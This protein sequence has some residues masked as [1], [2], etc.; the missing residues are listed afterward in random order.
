MALHKKDMIGFL[1]GQKFPNS[2]ETSSIPGKANQRTRYRAK[3]EALPGNSLLALCKKEFGKKP[4]SR[5][6]ASQ[7]SPVSD[8][9]SER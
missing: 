4:E 9:D 5:D 2:K 8:L 1:V 3:L 7:S 6:K